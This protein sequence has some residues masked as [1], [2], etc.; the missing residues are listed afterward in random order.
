MTKPIIFPN[1]TSAGYDLAEALRPFFASDW[2]I[3]ALPRGGVIVGAAIAQR[4]QLPL[5]TLVAR[6]IGHPFN[7]EFAIGAVTAA[8]PPI[9]NEPEAGKTDAAWRRHAITRGRDEARRRER[10]YAQ[11][12]PPLPTRD[13]T[14]VLVDDGL[15]TGL[16]ARAAIA[17]LRTTRPKRII[18][19]VP[20]APTETMKHLRPLVSRVVTLNRGKDFLG[21]VGAHYQ[22]FPQLTDEEVLA[23]LSASPA[24]PPVPSSDRRSLVARA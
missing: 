16:T 3:I 23:A 1:R 22:A 9:W 8:G 5:Q 10:V 19:A 17:Q 7:P 18:L 14:V 21:S 12:R 24:V 6:K 15:A 13:R 11:P 2:V 4:L 20:V